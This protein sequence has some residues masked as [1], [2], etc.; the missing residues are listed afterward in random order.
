M[1]VVVCVKYVPDVEGERRFSDRSVDRSG[2]DG[3]LNE[4]DEYAIEAALAIAELHG[5]SVTALAMGP[6]EAEEAV[7]R[8]LQMGV[9]EGVLVTDEALAGSDA[10]STA[11]VLAAA[12]RLLG[13]DQEVD[14]VLTG[15]ASLDGLTG[16][17]PV[18]LAA[19]LA[20]PHLGH[21]AAFTVRGDTIETLHHGPRTSDHFAAPL[22]AVVSVTDG[23][24]SPRYPDFR[25]IMAARKKTVTSLGLVDLCVPPASV[26]WSAARV[27]VVAAQPR[28]PRAD[29]VM[30]VDD[31]TAGRRLAD[32]LI[33]SGAI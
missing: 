30:L 9:N 16:V 26:G 12:V 1:K 33:E 2:G 7:R 23:A 29:R 15:V 32:F 5:G 28:A 4:P 13:H 22:P 20:W 24:N 10:F 8:A 11:A 18:L 14:L 31:G 21:A 3:V 19:E 25:G 17:V 27:E 6:P